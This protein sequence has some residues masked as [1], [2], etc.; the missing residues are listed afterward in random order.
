MQWFISG[1]ITTT[2]ALTH[3]PPIERYNL[4]VEALDSGF[5]R[6]TASTVVEV[7]VAVNHAPTMPEKQEFDVDENVLNGT[8]VGV[9]TAN[10]T[11]LVVDQWQNLTFYMDDETGIY[12][13]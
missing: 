9:V 2:D 5:P 13:L 4:E 10:D 11:D 7:N 8:D 12:Q 3:A 1:K 6:Q